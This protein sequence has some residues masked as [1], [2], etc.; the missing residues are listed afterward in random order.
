MLRMNA[1]GTAPTDNPFDVLDG[2]W[3]PYIWAIGLRNP[4]NFAVQP[5]G[6]IFVNDVGENAWEEI[7][8]LAEGANYGWPITEGPTSIVGQ[9]TPLYSYANEGGAACSITG[10]AFYNPSVVQFPVDYVGT[11]FYADYCGDQR[12]ENHRIAWNN[13]ALKLRMCWKDAGI[14]QAA[15]GSS[16]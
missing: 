7:N 16:S 11:Y 4:F 9:T 5:G 13:C 8:Q 10:G 12:P 2:T 15:T 1:D 6:L 14:S 3:G